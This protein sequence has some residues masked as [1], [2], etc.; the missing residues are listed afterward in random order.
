[1]I[2]PM[3]SMLVFLLLHFCVCALFFV[4]I[5]RPFFIVYN[6]SSEKEPLTVH[7]ILSIQWHG[8]YTDVKVAA[9]MTIPALLV[10]WIYA[11][12]PAFNAA[13]VIIICDILIA[14]PVALIA[15]A[16]TI[17][18]KF[19]QYKIEASVLQYLRSLKGA[20]ASVSAIFIV[21]G[22]SVV[23]VV[24]A[25][26]AAVL[27]L[28]VCQFQVLTIAPAALPWWGHI[29]T[30]IVAISIGALMFVVI[31]GLHI[32]PDTPVYSYFS[33]DQFLNHCAVNPVYNFIYS[34]HIKDDYKNQFQ[35]YD[36][37]WCAQ[38]FEGLFPTKG[39]P[40]IQLLNTQRPNIV[41]VVWESLCAYFME[42]L[43]GKHNVLPNMDRLANEGVL[44]TNCYASSFRTDRGL[45]AIL[46]GYPGQPTTS[47]IL[48]TKKLPN[49]PA[50]PRKLRDVAGYETMAVHGGELKIFHKADYYWASGHDRLVEEKD[51]PSDAPRT[52]WGV[53]DGIVFDWLAD[54]IID[55]TR[56]GTSPWFTTMQTLSSHEPFTVPYNRIA[57][58]AIDNAFAYTD[59]AFGHFIQRLKDSDAWKD[60]LVIVVGDH[61]VN[62]DLV[63]DDTRN[64]HQPLLLLGGAVRQPMKIDTIVSQS[65]IAATLLGQMGISHE[66][67]LFSRDVLA[68]TY[69]YPFALH[70]YN[71]AFMFRDATGVTHYDNV[72]QRVLDGPD[73][74]REQTAKVI[75][76]TLYSD[77]SKR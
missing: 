39:T 48:H 15:I 63:S 71:N 5:Q 54:D 57:D 59:D 69:T 72:S 77:L 24:A 11:H 37:Q 66:E 76:Q 42:S 55:K 32:R 38:H 12:V 51:F 73:Q 21:V 9:Y 61:G 70:T 65:D 50:L 36:P 67:F 7:N 74:Q 45:V 29:V 30:V 2:A 6:R 28:L 56:Q 33:N 60:L 10:T 44:F 8:L 18:Y 4:L 26:L 3:I 41:V 31:R 22:F 52:R 25:L 27:S 1:M 46:S 64:S 47:V 58:N 19:W 20:F 34:L 17:L 53:H 16:D 23:G 35:E 13:M 49:L 62:T 75:L 43:G 14:L 68:D 40:R